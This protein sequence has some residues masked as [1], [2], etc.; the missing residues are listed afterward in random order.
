[1]SAAD[2][3]TGDSAEILVFEVAGQRYGLWAGDVRELLRA[4][5]IVPLPQAPPA[6]LG[7]IDLRGRAVP[8]LDLRR[9]FGLPPRELDPAEHL[10]I[11]AAGPRLVGLRVD[12]AIELTRL[13]RAQLDDGAAVVP[14]APYVAGL[15]RLAGGL[16]IIHD[17]RTFLSAAEATR[18]DEAL[19]AGVPA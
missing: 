9:R 4:V 13:D 17:L 10:I 18:L 12:R 15:A 14:G 2:T 5:A 7:V 6:I 3:D 16:A 8:V 19:A 11:A 1:V